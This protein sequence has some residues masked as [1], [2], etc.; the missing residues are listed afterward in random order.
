MI[1]TL[2]K[3]GNSQALVIERPLMEALGINEQTKLQVVVSGGNLIITPVDVG[4]GSAQVQAS[5]RKMRTR[6]GGMLK[7]LAKG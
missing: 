2:Q 1:K 7:R 4:V 3:H 5:I 6:Y